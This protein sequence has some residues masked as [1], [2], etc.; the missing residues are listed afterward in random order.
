MKNIEYDE[1]EGPRLPRDQQLRRLR[2]VMDAELTEKQYRVVVGYYLENRNMVELANELGVNKS[3]ISRTLKRA[4]ARMR[5]CL[6]Y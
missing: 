6:K 5:R 1:Y 3:T 4:E 2:R